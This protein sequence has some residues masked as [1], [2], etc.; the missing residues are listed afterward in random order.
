VSQYHRGKT[1][2]EFT[3]ARDSEWQWYQLGR[4]PSVF[5]R[6]HA[7]PATQST[8]SKHWRQIYKYLS[9]NA[10]VTRHVDRES[11]QHESS[12]AR[13]QLNHAR[14]DVIGDVIQ[15]LRPASVACWSA[16]RFR[17]TRTEC[18]TRAVRT[19]VAPARGHGRSTGRT[20][21]S[22]N[23]CPALQPHTHTGMMILASSC[24]SQ[25]PRG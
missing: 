23:A 4:M 21:S 11:W 8:A 7:L 13:N 25:Q 24:R 15:R 19:C 14:R 2:L 1:N 17:W 3:E 18:S 20:A 6:P 22:S 12:T 10:P 5:Y 16:G 9:A